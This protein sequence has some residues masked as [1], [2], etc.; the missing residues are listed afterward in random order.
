MYFVL[1]YTAH[2]QSRLRHH[3]VLAELFLLVVV[4]DLNPGTVEICYLSSFREF[5]QKRHTNKLAMVSA[6]FLTIAANFHSTS[7]VYICSGE[8]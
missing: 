2:T 7:T 3:L 6:H 4:G 8:I 1:Q 5:Q